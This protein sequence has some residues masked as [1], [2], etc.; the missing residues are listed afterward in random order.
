[1]NVTAVLLYG[2]FTPCQDYDEAPRSKRVTRYCHGERH[3]LDHNSRH[4]NQCLKGGYINCLSVGYEIF[5]ASTTRLALSISMTPRV[6]NFYLFWPQGP[7]K[8]S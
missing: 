8:L 1:M 4:K 6:P 5:T 2:I 7:L 3:N